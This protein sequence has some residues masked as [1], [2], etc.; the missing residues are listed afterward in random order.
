MS[1]Y[2]VKILEAN[3][4][5]HNVKR[6]LIEKPK[7]YTFTP[8]QATD[9]A[10]NLPDWKDKLRPFTFTGLT[11]W[12]HLELIVKIYDDHEG[13]TDMMGK[14]NAGAELILHEPFG[15]IA[16]NGPG[17]FIAGGTGITPFIAIFRE[18]YKTKKIMGN[19]LI[20]CNRTSAD[21][22]L[23]PELQQMLG[24]NY[25]NVFTR[26][27]VIGYLDRHIDRDFLVQSIS[28]FSRQ[29]YVC[30]PDKFVK[31]ITAILLDLGA[32]PEALVIEK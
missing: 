17:V 23:G 31:D 16:Y 5:N 7:G 20:F 11:K 27:N 6:F 15:A 2:V 8:G 1:E 10:I 22:I 3:F 13:V 26:E 4:I 18:L 21:I 25:M 9:V 14:L 28:N 19:Q 12:E 32:K 30:G 29:F 24:D